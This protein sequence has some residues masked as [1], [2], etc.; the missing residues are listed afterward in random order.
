MIPFLLKSIAELASLTTEMTT[1]HLSPVLWSSESCKIASLGMFEVSWV[2]SNR[3]VAVM[4]SNAPTSGRSMKSVHALW[5][6]LQFWLVTQEDWE[7][8]C[9][10]VAARHK[11]RSTEAPLLVFPTSISTA[12]QDVPHKPHRMVVWRRRSTI[13]LPTRT[14][15]ITG[16]QSWT[17]S[18]SWLEV[19]KPE[20]DRTSRLCKEK[21]VHHARQNWMYDEHTCKFSLQLYTNE[22]FCNIA[23]QPWILS[24]QSASHDCAILLCHYWSSRSIFLDYLGVRLGTFAGSTGGPCECDL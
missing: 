5:I 11:E 23:Q 18:S 15:A 7:W 2:G 4:P 14:S 3:E 9:A 6:W 13:R 10:V 20:S 1:C 19:N 24:C 12:W 22:Q 21:G 8:G 17:Q 16:Q